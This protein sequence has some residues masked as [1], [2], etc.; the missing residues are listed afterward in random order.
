MEDQLDEIL[1]KIEA[2]DR[3]EGKQDAATSKV[4]EDLDVIWEE[5]SGINEGRKKDA[6]EMMEVK[7]SLQDSE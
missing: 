6:A 3:L 5:I 7:K 2:M 1:K 4:T